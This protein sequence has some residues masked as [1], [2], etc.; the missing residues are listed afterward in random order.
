MKIYCLNPNISFLG[1]G[2]KE[3]PVRD[4]CI[5]S[6]DMTVELANSLIAADSAAWTMRPLKKTM[7]KSQDPVILTAT[8]AVASRDSVKE[9][10]H[11]Y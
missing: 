2:G 10:D 1:I 7:T 11:A 8:A 9:E 4:G 5:D 3:F 6:S